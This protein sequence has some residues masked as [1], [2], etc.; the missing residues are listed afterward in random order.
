MHSC[1]I[2]NPDASSFYQV[3]ISISS[4]WWTLSSKKFQNLATSV[5]SALFARIKTPNGKP[6]QLLPPSVTSQQPTVSTSNVFAIIVSRPAVP[7]DFNAFASN[8]TSLLQAKL[9][10]SGQLSIGDVL[11]LME[12]I[13]CKLS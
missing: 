3:Y 12:K 11:R 5:A 8:L 2:R 6:Y 7:K 9:P 1:V 13:T 4:Y 10:V